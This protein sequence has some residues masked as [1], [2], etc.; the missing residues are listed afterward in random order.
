MPATGGKPEIGKSFFYI[1]LR[2]H[3]DQRNSFSTVYPPA[4]V[5]SFTTIVQN[6][7]HLPLT[8]GTPFDS[9]PLVPRSQTEVNQWNSP[10]Y[11]KR[12]GVPRRAS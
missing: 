2:G 12:I 5:Q 11:R 9:I 6:R 10:L 4:R 7:T 8:G 3:R 1:R